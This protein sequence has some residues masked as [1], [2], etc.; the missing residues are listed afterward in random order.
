[1]NRTSVRSQ[2]L[3][4]RPALQSLDTSYCL[5]GSA[6]LV[7][8]GT[9]LD[10][11]EDI[12]ILTDEHGA[13]QLARA[14]RDQWQTSNHAEGHRQFRSEYARYAFA[15]GIVEVMG[16]LH[17]RQ[18][19]EWLPVTVNETV[20]IDGIAVASLAE[21]QRL[22]TWFGRAKDEEKLNRLAKQS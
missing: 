7:M 21:L 4:L 10:Q 3:Q 15:H 18:Q 19:A 5:I 16:A 13:Q 12:D 20:E 17:I 9:A 22:L 1:M 11:C 2:L 8:H 6:A 14:W